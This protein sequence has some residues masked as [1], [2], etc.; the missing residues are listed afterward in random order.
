MIRRIIIA[1][2]SSIIIALAATG[3]ATSAPPIAPGGC[4]EDSIRTAHVGRNDAVCRPLEW[5]TDERPTGE[6]EMAADM[7]RFCGTAYASHRYVLALLSDSD[8][9]LIMTCDGPEG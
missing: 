3:C 8:A 6:R 4:S 5:W 1:S 2:A 9:L 7:I